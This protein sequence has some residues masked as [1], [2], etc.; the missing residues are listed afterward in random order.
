MAKQNRVQNS[1]QLKALLSQALARIEAG[2]SMEDIL[3]GEEFKSIA[4]TVADVVGNQ[5]L[6]PPAEKQRQQPIASHVPRPLVT[7]V[8]GRGSGPAPKE[9]SL[10]SI[11]K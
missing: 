7:A 4:R 2:E 3:K 1:D 5:N 10:Q 11:R 8:G 9:P 6:R